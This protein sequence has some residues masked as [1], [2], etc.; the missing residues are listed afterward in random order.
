MEVPMPTPSPH[1]SRW[2][3]G[4]LGVA[5]GGIMPTLPKLPDN[6]QTVAYLD[7]DR[8]CVDVVVDHV[9]VQTVTLSLSQLREYRQITAE[10]ASRR[11]A[12][13]IDPASL[14]STSATTNPHYWPVKE[15]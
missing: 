14:A 4:G 9:V 5:E 10:Q 12:V 6:V 15:D 11:P 8:L 13:Q 7:G 1:P 3:A 2:P